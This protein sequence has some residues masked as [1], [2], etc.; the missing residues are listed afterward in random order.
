MN[1]T[2]LEEDMK[3]LND[4]F[5]DFMKK[6]KKSENAK[7]N[8]IREKIIDIFVVY[9]EMGIPSE[10]PCYEVFE[11]FKK[12]LIEYGI[13]QIFGHEMKGCRKNSFDFILDC[14]VKEDRV[15]I[16][17]EFKHNASSVSDLP[18]FVQIY[19]NNKGTK[20]TKKD[21]H[22]FYYEQYLP[23]VLDFIQN[24]YN[25]NLSLPSYDEYLKDLT[26]ETKKDS[27]HYLIKQYYEKDGKKGMNL[28]VKESIRQFLKCDD[29]SDIDSLCRKLKEQTK[30]V[31]LLEK[32]GKFYCEEIK[33]EQVNVEKVKGIKN[34]NTIIFETSSQYEIH[35]LLRWKNG[36]GCI[37]PA[38]QIKLIH[39]GREKSRSSSESEGEEEL[40]AEKLHKSFGK[41]KGYSLVELKNFC[42]LRKI[43]SKGNK[44]DLV[45]RLM[46]S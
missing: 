7:F 43:D 12:S 1:S 10:N 42:K 39:K 5:V 37:G 21:Y 35:C 19:T 46:M 14:R 30:K 25:V 8:K 26:K 15:K 6:S 24:K 17:I 11:N 33:E 27:F 36:N 4:H 34:G 22:L 28:I 40:C 3:Y 31:F 13:V 44:K 20:I 2:R 9:F 29:L 38:W 23:K 45:S 16:L 18:Q 32:E 41:R